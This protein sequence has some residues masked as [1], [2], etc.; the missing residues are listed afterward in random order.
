MP[1]RTTDSFILLSFHLWPETTPVQTHNQS[2][3]AFINIKGQ[4]TCRNNNYSSLAV[5]HHR[6]AKVGLLSIIVIELYVQSNAPTW[7]RLTALT[8]H[9]HEQTNLRTGRQHFAKCMGILS[10]NF[11]LS[12]IFSP[13]P[14]RADETKATPGNTVIGGACKNWQTKSPEEISNIL[15][16]NFL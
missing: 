5:T 6:Y 16:L 11:M 14:P 8:V 3:S 1:T 2:N 10:I 12:L 7:S 9:Y 13:P 4:Y 15:L